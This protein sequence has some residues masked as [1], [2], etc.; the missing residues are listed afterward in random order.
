MENI[1]KIK[2]KSFRKLNVPVVID[3]AETRILI[4]AIE[5]DDEK[6]WKRVKPVQM[7]SR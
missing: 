4:F 5:Y 1:K 7:G 6:V 3:N 2:F